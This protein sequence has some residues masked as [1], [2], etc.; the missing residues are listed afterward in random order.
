MSIER[1]LLISRGYSSS[2]GLDRMAAERA[3]EIHGLISDSSPLIKGLRLFSG[4]ELV[5][6]NFEAYDP[7][8][9]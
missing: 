5:Q 9:E 3:D 8:L 7:N 2:S 1:D 4:L 6:A